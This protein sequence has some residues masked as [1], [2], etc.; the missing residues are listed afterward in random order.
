MTSTVYK[1]TCSGCNKCQIVSCCG[2]R[3]GFVPSDL[4]GP[5][6]ICDPRGPCDGH[7]NLSQRISSEAFNPIQI[8]EQLRIL[9]KRRSLSQEQVALMI[10]TYQSAIARVESGSV[11]PRLD[12]L[13]RIAKA[14]GTKMKVSFV[15][16]KNVR[17]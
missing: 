11:I 12:F 10:G 3:H 4:T 13:D 7:G 17:S 2:C 6:H 9:R 16:V 5:H 8:A 1:E 15:D 14:L